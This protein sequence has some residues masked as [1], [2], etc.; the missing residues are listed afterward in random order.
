V[1]VVQELLL[2]LDE[3]WRKHPELHKYPVICLSGM[4]KRCIA[5]Y[6]TYIRFPLQKKKP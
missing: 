5:T 1:I 3:H 4:A 2:L 6:Q